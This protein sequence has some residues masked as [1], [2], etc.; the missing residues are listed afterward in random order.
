MVNDIEQGYDLNCDYADNMPLRGNAEEF[1]IPF[2]D[3]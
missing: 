2:H 3:L 1:L